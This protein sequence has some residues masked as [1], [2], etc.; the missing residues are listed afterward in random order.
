M[1]WLDIAP[2][3]AGL[4]ESGVRLGIHTLHLEDWRSDEQQSNIEHGDGYLFIVLKLVPLTSDELSAADLGV[5]LGADYMAAVHKSPFPL[6]SRRCHGS[7]LVESNV[8]Q[9]RPT[10][11]RG[12]RETISRG[13]RQPES[14]HLTNHFSEWKG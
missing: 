8:D 11:C 10:L 7:R 12:V 5:F 14:S 13:G 4:E 2:S 3:D 1:A 6:S 9:F